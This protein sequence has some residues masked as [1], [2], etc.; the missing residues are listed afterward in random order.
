MSP[1]RRTFCFLCGSVY[2]ETEAKERFEYI[3]GRCEQ[4]VEPVRVENPFLRQFVPGS[5]WF[6]FDANFLSLE[7]L[8]REFEVHLKWWTKQLEIL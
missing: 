2:H 3:L 7:E 8:K 1:K 6:D 4:C 5:L